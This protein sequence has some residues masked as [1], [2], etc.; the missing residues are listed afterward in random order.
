MLRSNRLGTGEGF[1]KRKIQMPFERQSLVEQRPALLSA[2]AGRL[3][4]II[5]K[6]DKGYKIVER[7]RLC[8]ALV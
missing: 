3:K 8:F 6:N 5:R 1:M 2:R 7:Y 4:A